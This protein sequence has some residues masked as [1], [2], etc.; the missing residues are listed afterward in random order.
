LSA[1]FAPVDSKAGAA[2]ADILVKT[3]ANREAILTVG[4]GDDRV[5]SSGWHA[6]MTYMGSGHIQGNPQGGRTAHQAYRSSAP[7]FRRNLVLWHVVGLYYY[8][9]VPTIVPVVVKIP[10]VLAM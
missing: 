9:F 3:E 6:S 5:K 8:N 2:I 7:R 4:A 1:T 10:T